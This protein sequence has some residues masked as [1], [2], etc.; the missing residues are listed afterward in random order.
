MKSE[1]KAVSDL[2]L[3][4]V[5]L[6]KLSSLA[7]DS[8]DE[9]QI[10][11]CNRKVIGTAG[12]REDEQYDNNDDTNCRNDGIVSFDEY[13]RGIGDSGGDDENNG[14]HNHNHNNSNNSK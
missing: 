13:S 6:K 5:F 11:R 2:Y 10:C 1:F 7:D 12:P 3:N 8:D 9:G 14:N 4:P